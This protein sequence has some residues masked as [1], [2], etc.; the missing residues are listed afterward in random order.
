MRHAWLFVQHLR[1]SRLNYRVPA[2]EVHPETLEGEQSPLCTCNAASKDGTRRCNAATV[3][4]GIS[5]NAGGQLQE[6]VRW[7][8][9][10]PCR[11]GWRCAGLQHAV[12]RAGAQCPARGGEHCAHLLLFNRHGILLLNRHGNSPAQSSWEFSCSIVMGILLLNCRVDHEFRVVC[13]AALDTGSRNILRRSAC[14]LRCWHNSRNTPPSD[15]LRVPSFRNM[16]PDQGGIPSTGTY[17]I[18]VFWVTF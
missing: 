10:I 7:R 11:S 1:L 6:I 13:H 4:L 18:S 5:R 12:G 17:R 2:C 16:P 15:G 9:E 14:V 3:T 8:Y